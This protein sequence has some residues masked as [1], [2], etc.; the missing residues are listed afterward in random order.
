MKARSLA[1]FLALACVG[2]LL[3]WHS[4]DVG[5]QD[6]AGNAEATMLFPRILLGAWIVLA[7]GAVVEA[8]LAAVRSAEPWAFGRLA[9]FVLVVGAWVAAIP[10]LGFLI[11]SVGFAFL[12]LVGFGFRKPAALV[13]FGLLLPVSVW[14]LFTFVIQIGLPTS[15][16]FARF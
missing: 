1:F 10:Y 2:V 8:G 4:F 6:S 3:F 15:P 9:A 11:A 12:S 5:Y 16:W 14:L 13:L 7:G